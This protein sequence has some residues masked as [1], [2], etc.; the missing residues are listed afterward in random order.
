MKLYLS[1]VRVRY[2]LDFELSH[3]LYSLSK[4]KNGI[5][6][7]SFHEEDLRDFGLTKKLPTG[8]QVLVV[9]LTLK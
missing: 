4:E 8:K 7:I 3:P 9:N 6:F 5:P 1:C 2:P